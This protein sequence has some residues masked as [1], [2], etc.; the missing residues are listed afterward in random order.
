MKITF[1][2]KIIYEE[3]EGIKRSPKSPYENLPTFENIREDLKSGKVEIEL[4]LPW[5]NSAE[6]TIILKKKNE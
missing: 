4:I 2:A 1:K 5:D 3:P 6:P